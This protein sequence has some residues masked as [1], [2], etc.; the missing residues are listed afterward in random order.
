MPQLHFILQAGYR[1]LSTDVTL[2]E[3]T[4]QRSSQLIS[5][6]VLSYMSALNHELETFAQ[7]LRDMLSGVKQELTDFLPKLQEFSKKAIINGDFIR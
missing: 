1:V 4:Q 7:E 2:A 5:T 3:F 6:V